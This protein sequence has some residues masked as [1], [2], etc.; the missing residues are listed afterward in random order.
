MNVICLLT[1]APE[2][3]GE[4]TYPSD[5][6]Q[7]LVTDMREATRR[8]R[9]RANAELLE[10]GCIP[11][12]LV[13]AGIGQPERGIS[14]PVSGRDVGTHW[15]RGHWRR[16]PVGPSRS[17]IR[18]VWIRPTLVKADKDEPLPGYIYVVDTV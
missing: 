11:I 1:A 9:D 15:R 13:A 16:Q 5:T 4:R 14:D 17:S 18:L 2:E 3:I 12:R 7:S 6:P 10:K 8:Q